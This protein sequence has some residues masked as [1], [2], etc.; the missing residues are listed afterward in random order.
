MSFQGSF[1]TES[2]VTKV[3]GYLL[4][5][6]SFHV[7]IQDSLTLKTFLTIDADIRKNILFMMSLDMKLE[8]GFSFI[9]FAT[10]GAW[11]IFL[12]FVF[13]HV[14]LIH[15]LNIG[16]KWTHLTAVNNILRRR[17]RFCRLCSKD[18][19]FW[20]LLKEW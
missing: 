7:I 20:S 13:L 12:R 17:L 19:Q 10:N 5:K 6:M 16:F 11:I 15:L 9:I 18:T 3:T 14:I 1:G 4:R 8:S 2:F